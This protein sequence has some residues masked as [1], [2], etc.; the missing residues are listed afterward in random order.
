MSLMVISISYLYMNINSNFTSV[1]NDRYCAYVQLSI[2]Y[3]P[4]DTVKRNH[5]FSDLFLH[6]PAGLELCLYMNK[7][8]LLLL[9]PEVYIVTISAFFHADTLLLLS[10]KLIKLLRYKM[11][12]KKYTKFFYGHMGLRSAPVSSLLSKPLHVVSK[13][14]FNIASI[15]LHGKRLNYFLRIY[16]KSPRKLR[17]CGGHKKRAIDGARSLAE[18]EK[19]HYYWIFGPLNIKGRLEGRHKN[20]AKIR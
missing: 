10:I 11:F 4:G 3:C 15:P 17:V 5:Q 18:P 2:L 14:T 19:S 9:I 1:P 8:D 16:H 7:S 20:Q 12:I 6:H 13:T